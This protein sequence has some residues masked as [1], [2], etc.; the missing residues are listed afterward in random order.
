VLKVLETLTQGVFSCF[1]SLFH[2][3]LLNFKFT[4]NCHLHSHT[5]TLSLMDSSKFIFVNSLVLKYSSCFKLFQRM[6]SS[7]HQS[8]SPSQMSISLGLDVRCRSFK[9]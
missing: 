6:R 3:K 9:T 1:V 2:S 4:G 8:Q 5:V 7:R